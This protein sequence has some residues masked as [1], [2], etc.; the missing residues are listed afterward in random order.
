MMASELNVNLTCVSFTPHIFAGLNPTL[1]I[2]QKMSNKK[3]QVFS[4]LSRPNTAFNSCDGK[5]HK[6]CHLPAFSPTPP[7]KKKKRYT[8]ED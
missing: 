2:K 5:T 8:P 1:G 7:P 6:T 3:C 4:W